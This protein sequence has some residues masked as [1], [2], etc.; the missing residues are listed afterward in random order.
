MRFSNGIFEDTALDGFY[1]ESRIFILPKRRTLV[2]KNDI[3][4]PILHKNISK[5]NM[6]LVEQNML[7][8]RDWYPIYE[9]E[10]SEFKTLLLDNPDTFGR[11]IRIIQNILTSNRLH[12]DRK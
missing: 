10:N 7:F 12:M 11:S 4:K 2:V 8:N 1:E 3:L 9:K 5:Q 6:Q